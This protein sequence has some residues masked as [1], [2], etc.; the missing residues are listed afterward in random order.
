LT[1]APPLAGNL[2]DWIWRLTHDS[3]ADDLR[4]DRSPA[5]RVEVTLP[6]PSIEKLTTS[7]P[8]SVRSRFASRW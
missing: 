8:P 3:T 7:L 2:S 6:L 1:I 5:I 4:L